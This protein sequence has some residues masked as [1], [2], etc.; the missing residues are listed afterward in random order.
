[1]KSK[2]LK[3]GKSLNKK[4][5]KNIKGELDNN[6]PPQ[7]LNNCFTGPFHCNIHQLPICPPINN[8][9]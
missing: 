4:E 7:T 9:N 6:C 3:V 5:L 1:M 8:E 2:I